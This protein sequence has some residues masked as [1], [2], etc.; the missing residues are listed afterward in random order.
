M[1]NVLQVQEQLKNFSKEQLAQE[2]QRPSGTAPQ[3]LVLSELQRRK[4]ME[5]SFAAQKDAQKPETT[6]AEDV[7]TAA[8]MPQQG[9][10]QIARSMA[11]NTDM[12]NNTMKMADGGYLSS[13]SPDVHA[14][15][16]DNMI[17]TMASRTGMS[18][19][20]YWQSLSPAAQQQNAARIDRNRMLAFEP[21]GDGLAFPTQEDLSRRYNNDKYGAGIAALAPRPDTAP[22]RPNPNTSPVFSAIAA[23][24][25]QTP[26]I[27]GDLKAD[28]FAGP[29][30]DT[31]PRGIGPMLTAAQTGED[32]M[33]LPGMPTAPGTGPAA[34]LPPV[35]RSEEDMLP[36]W[37]ADR[38][39]PA[40]GGLPTFNPWMP[41]V[42]GEDVPASITPVT[43]DDGALDPYDIAVAEAT[44]S[45][46]PAA[47]EAPDPLTPPEQ[48]QT[49]PPLSPPAASI[50]S[51]G[52]GT[53]ASGGVAASSSESGPLSDLEKQFQRDKWLALAQAGFALMASEQ[54][55]LGRAMG[56]AGLYG[57]GAFR[58][59][60]QDYE[61]SHAAQVEEELARA[62]LAARMSGGGGGGGGGG[63]MGV[64]DLIAVAK[65]LGEQIEPLRMAASEGDTVAEELLS[66]KEA[67]LEYITSVLGFGAATGTATGSEVDPDYLDTTGE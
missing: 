1:M 57:M 38:G 14:Y 51:G 43:P 20:E 13:V 16:Q 15:T 2:M 36:P 54:P 67:Q 55:T 27:Y 53:S 50:T 28:Q 40:A 33:W 45:E 58:Q 31:P 32:Q 56:E 46:A 9:L 63:G 18:P 42:S 17:R 6:V 41:G 7:V 47:D 48:G 35:P 26:D 62:A 65:M 34:P 30:V 23:L 59:A 39:P 64:R 24:S 52:G 66:R 60:R 10:G 12:A 4:R 29:G 37:L 11:P 61:T 44:A 19:A 8:G 25:G 22:T 3:Y 49:Q 5:T 21:K